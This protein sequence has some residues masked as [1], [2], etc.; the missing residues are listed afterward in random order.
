V[1]QL[2]NKQRV[3]GPTTVH[4]SDATTVVDAQSTEI[5]TTENLR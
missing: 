4:L 3:R 5:N 2:I 1:A